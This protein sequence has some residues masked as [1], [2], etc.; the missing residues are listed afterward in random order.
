VS[1]FRRTGS[2]WSR[3]PPTTPRAN[4]PSDHFSLAGVY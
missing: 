4:S 2:G 3:T 1:A